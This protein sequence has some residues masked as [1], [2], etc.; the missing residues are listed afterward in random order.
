MARERRLARAALTVIASL[1]LTA[2]G[3]GSETTTADRRQALEDYVAEVQPIR[4][5]INELLDR[6][7]PILE[8]YRDG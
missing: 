8:G 3:C 4:L 1:A 7:D 2:T 6:A 5:G